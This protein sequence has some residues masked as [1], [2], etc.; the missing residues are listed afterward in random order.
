M[1]RIDDANELAHYIEYANLDNTATEKDI[2]KFLKRAKT[3]EF[4]SVLIMPCYVKLAKES[5]KDTNIK[6]GTVI[7]FPLGFE[8]T[9]AKI[10]ETKIALEDG[11]DEIEMVINPSYVKSENF[12]AIENEIKEI[13]NVMGDKILKVIIETKL[14]NDAEKVEVSK[15]AEKSGADYVRTTSGFNG[16]STSLET[17]HDINLIK[18]NAPI[19]KIKAAGGINEYKL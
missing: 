15:I 12:K 4:H 9:K 2:L 1:I 16:V 17:I 19:I 7:G 8:T 18:K 11:A 14:L 6:V 3:F 13:K 10:A 5:L